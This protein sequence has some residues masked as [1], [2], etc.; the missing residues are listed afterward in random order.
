MAKVP[1][2]RPD[3]RLRVLEGSLKALTGVQRVLFAGQVSL[4]RTVTF[5][6][7]FERRPDDIFI[8]TFPKSGTTLTQMMIHQLRSDGDMDI[9]H[10]NAVVP[11]LETEVIGGN[12]ELLNALPS[13]RVFKTHLRYEYQAPKARY[14]YIVRDVRDVF[15]SGYH[16]QCRGLGHR[17]KP[18]VFFQSFMN[19][20]PHNGNWFQHL[21]SWWPHRHD[22]NVLFLTYEGMVG[23]LEGT[24]RKVAAF[25]GFPIDESQMPRILE[26]CSVAYMKRHEPKFDPRLHQTDPGV[27][28]FIRKGKVGSWIE[29]LP[30][31]DREKLEKLARGLAGRL[32]GSGE[33]PF[34]FL[35]RG[36]AKPAGAPRPHLVPPDREAAAGG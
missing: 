21:E 24:V 35:A 17:V 7:K 25:C 11:W 23:D 29:E 27:G 31:P 16:H 2:R 33:D 9:P 19:A 28:D 36:G 13:P 12:F 22:P 32:D 10:I 5:D 14:I 6:Y 15:V 4:R 3:L 34:T 18:E 30:A 20:M 8:A 1:T 26:R